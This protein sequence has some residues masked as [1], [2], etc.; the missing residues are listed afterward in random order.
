MAQQIVGAD[1]STIVKI[2]PSFGAMRVSARPYEATAWLQFSAKSANGPVFSLR[3]ASSNLLMIR[4][5]VIGF[6]TTTGY[7]AAQYQDFSV[8]IARSWTGADSGGTTLTLTGNNCKLRTSLAALTSAAAFI[9]TTGVITAGTR[10]VDTNNIGTYGQWFTAT[11][12]GIGWGL[13][14]IFDQGPG[15][16]PL[17]CAQN[18]GIVIQAGTAMGAGGV[19][20]LTVMVECAETTTALFS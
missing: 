8:F 19:G 15:D 1:G 18:E 16:Y 5:V 14:T 13:T 4:K 6:I 12:A 20:I 11:T 3:N 7:T 9:S 2:D 10:T 17:I